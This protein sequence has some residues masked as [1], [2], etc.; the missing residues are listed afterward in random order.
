MSI[1]GFK[2]GIERDLGCRLF[3]H[4]NFDHGRLTH[5]PNFCGNAA[6]FL[7]PSSYSN[8]K[9]NGMTKPPSLRK[10]IS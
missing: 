9:I 5:L 4:E 1:C 8:C 6:N 2:H 3:R 7:V 10:V